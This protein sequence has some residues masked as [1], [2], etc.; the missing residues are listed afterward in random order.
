MDFKSLFFLTKPDIDENAMR[1][2]SGRAKYQGK[3]LNEDKKQ[4]IKELIQNNKAVKNLLI[5]DKLNRL[6][7]SWSLFYQK[8]QY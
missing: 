2:M 1:V 3:D 6:F 4:K 7:H 5:K 8:F